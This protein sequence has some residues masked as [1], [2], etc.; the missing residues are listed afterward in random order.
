MRKLRNP[1]SLK[2][3]SFQENLAIITISFATA[4]VLL[5][6]IAIFS[7]LGTFTPSLSGLGCATIAA[8]AIAAFWML[9]DL[10][11]RRGTRVRLTW[12]ASITFFVSMLT[13][14]FIAFEFQTSAFFLGFPEV[15]GVCLSLVGLVH[16]SLRPRNTAK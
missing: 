9:T 15:I 11:Y 6:F 7:I 16:H 12:L 13:G 8:F 4:S 10:A 2:K 5:P 14:V 1:T 3:K